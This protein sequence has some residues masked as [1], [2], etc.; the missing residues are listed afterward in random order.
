MSK[1][2][3]NI[4]EIIQNINNSEFL[5]AESKSYELLED[6]PNN[7]HLLHIL[8]ISFFR[9]NKNLDALE[10][11]N[12]AISLDK[13]NY[14]FLLTKGSILRQLSKFN[15][16]IIIYNKL[17][18]MK[19]DLWKVYFNRANLLSEMRRYKESIEDYNKVLQIDFN[20]YEAYFNKANN[21]VYLRKYNDALTNYDECLNISEN[22]IPAMLEKTKVLL[23]LGNF[24]KAIEISNKIDLI[25]K[26]NLINIILKGEI[27][28]MLHKLNDAEA[29]FNQALKLNPNS[30]EA[31]GGISDIYHI[32]G[33]HDK[34]NKMNIK[35]IGIIRFSLKKGVRFLNHYEKK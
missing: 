12:K 11:L 15:D 20:N 34:A 33:E 25:D 35:D 5:T 28:L 10:F 16:A 6:Y 2:E 26:N 22:Y 18:E 27:F 17:I 23:K 14:T 3:K 9:Q 8:S 24:E 29:C 31:F 1:I 21:L 4:N 7:S 19:P 32:K 13:K 30:K